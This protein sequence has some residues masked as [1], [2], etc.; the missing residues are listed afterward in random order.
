MVMGEQQTSRK[1]VPDVSIL[2]M[3]QGLPCYSIRSGMGVEDSLAQLR[4][5][6]GKPAFAYTHSDERAPGKEVAGEPP[7][8]HPDGGKGCDQ[9]GSKTALPE[10]LGP[11][12]WP[13][14]MLRVPVQEQ[15]AQG[16]EVSQ[17]A[18]TVRSAFVPVA[19]DV[20]RHPDWRL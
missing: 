12:Y 10:R 11:L 2:S 1:A 18:L 6:P 5:L 13:L 7:G 19:Q 14:G 4:L 17:E 3:Y 20:A 9:V 8:A 16:I 15:H